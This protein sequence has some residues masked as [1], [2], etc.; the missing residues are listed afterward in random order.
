[1]CS[2]NAAHRA[3]VVGE[4]VVVRAGKIDIAAAVDGHRGHDAAARLRSLFP[5]H[6]SRCCVDSVQRAALGSNVQPR[7]EDTTHNN[8]SQESALKRM[9]D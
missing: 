4:H 3:G 2:S 7:R 8:A 1:M 9:N 6:V 5:Q